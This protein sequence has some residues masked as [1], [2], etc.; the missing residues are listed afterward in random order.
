MVVKQVL[1]DLA[2]SD[3]SDPELN[4]PVAADLVGVL[5]AL[6]DPMRLAIVRCLADGGEKTCAGLGMPIS[7]STLTHHLHVLRAA[8]IIVQREEG[9][10]RMTSLDREGLEGRYPGLLVSVLAAPAPLPLD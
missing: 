10:R 4:P 8:G 3:S 1:H 7:K 2:A 6:G 5:Q 9:T